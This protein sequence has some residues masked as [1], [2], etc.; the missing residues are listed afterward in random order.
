M[1]TPRGRNWPLLAGLVL[2]ALA[3]SLVT[4]TNLVARP[5]VAPPM[6]ISRLEVLAAGQGPPVLAYAGSGIGRSARALLLADP[7]GEAPAP[8]VLAPSIPIFQVDSDG[9]LAVAA[10]R[11][12]RIVTIAVSDG[13]QPQLLGSVRLNSAKAPGSISSLVLVG[14]RAVA[15][16]T[17]A[18]GLV[19]LDL[20]DP[21]RPGVLDQLPLSG[22]F[23]DMLAANGR[24]YAA[25]MKSG[26]WQLSY[27]GDRL[28][29]VR[30][31]GLERAWRLARQGSR[32]AA[33]S[34]QGELALYD[35]EAADRPRLAGRQQ[36]GAEIRGVALGAETLHLCLADGR[37]QEYGLAA[38]P[39]LQ[40]RGGLQL[41]GQ[42]LQLVRSDD[43]SLLLCTL[44]GIGGCVID[45]RHAGA[46]VV[47]GW[48]AVAGETI[49]GLA[50]SGDMVLA[51]NG[52][53]LR[54]HR[55]ADLLGQPLRVTPLFAG[56]RGGVRL[57][58]WQG[59]GVAY[60]AAGVAALGGDAFAATDSTAAQSAPPRL[61]VPAGR[62]VRLYERPGGSREFI[63]AGEIQV[64]YKVAAALQRDGR[65]YLLGE[66]ALDIFACTSSGDCQ[67]LGGIKAFAVGQAMA[68]VAADLLLVADRQHGLL[69]V[70]VAAPAAPR[71]VASRPLPGFMQQTGGVYDLLVSGRRAYVARSELGIQVVDLTRP[72]ELQVVQQIDTPGLARRLAMHDDLLLV[73]DHGKGIQ[74]IDTRSPLCRLIATVPV[75]SHLADMVVQGDEILTVNTAGMLTRLPVPVRVAEP[76]TAGGSLGRVVL[77]E[78]LAAGRYQL[79]LYDEARLARAGFAW[80]G[81]R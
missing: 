69:L 67:R 3:A 55:F 56:Q 20:A 72:A 54:L 28:Q 51:G 46:P 64:G 60:A 70:D 15:A 6:A 22:Q 35:L 40:L 63:P 49:I 10:T 37:L 30:L 77:P 78:G 8:L 5:S 13:Q 18:A 59:A 7:V 1:T 68:W 65:F 48:L 16:L 9:R 31:P 32:L 80:Q 53:G 52:H 43:A 17:Q 11:G 23:T 44:A 19:L 34:L 71:V 33:V 29:A 66:D 75:S 2:L 4:A 58:N 14:S 39:R 45:I 61:A 12:Q 25:C 36:L 41:P 26:V 42:P 24:I 74:V 50:H 21:Y 47:A 27:A 73:A 81:R 38:W 76:G 62:A 79:V 57:T